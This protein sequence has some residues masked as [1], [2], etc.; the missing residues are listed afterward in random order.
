M[1]RNVP[2]NGDTTSVMIAGGGPIGLG[3]ACELGLRGVDCVLIEKRDGAIN[4]PKQSMVARAT[5]SSAAAGA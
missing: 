2:D 1:S 5:W 4:V 3:L